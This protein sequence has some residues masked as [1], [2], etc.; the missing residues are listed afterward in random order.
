MHGF[1][2]SGILL[3][4]VYDLGSLIEPWCRSA[5]I[6]ESTIP[7]TVFWWALIEPWFRPFLFFP[8][9]N[10]TNPWYDSLNRTSVLIIA[11]SV[12]ERPGQSAPAPAGAFFVLVVNRILGARKENLA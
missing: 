10:L 12:I 2:S 4:P 7:Y 8:L 3:V 5:D 11:S 6:S 9:A 1:A